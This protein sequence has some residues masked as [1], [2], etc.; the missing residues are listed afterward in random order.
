MVYF[1]E[2]SI[3]SGEGTT[4]QLPHEDVDGC[5]ELIPVGK[6]AEIGNIYDSGDGDRDR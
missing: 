3:K 6:G 2:E 4:I 5:Y 1:F